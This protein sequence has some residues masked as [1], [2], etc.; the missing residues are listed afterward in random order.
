MGNWCT[1]TA[2]ALLLC[3]CRLVRR[4]PEIQEGQDFR[5]MRPLAL[6]PTVRLVAETGIEPATFG[7]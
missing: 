1:I 3:I 5:L 6:K 4:H 2:R 7:V